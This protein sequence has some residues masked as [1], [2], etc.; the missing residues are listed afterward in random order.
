MSESSRRVIA[1]Y[2]TQLTPVRESLLDFLRNKYGAFDCAFYFHNPT[3][4]ASVYYFLTT[5]KGP[6]RCTFRA[7]ARL[8]WVNA[9]PPP[10]GYTVPVD[11]TYGETCASLR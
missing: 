9:G 11:E 2:K 6:T 1:K 4:E 10:A 3:A 8:V 7:T 5:S